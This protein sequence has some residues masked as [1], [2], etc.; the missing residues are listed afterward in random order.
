M[1][2]MKIPPLT[3]RSASSVSS[4]LTVNQSPPPGVSFPA[5]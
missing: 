2:L 1:A 5:G 4:A 3:V